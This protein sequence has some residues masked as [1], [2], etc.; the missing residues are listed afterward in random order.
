MDEMNQMWII[1]LIY[2]IWLTW[3]TCDRLIQVLWMELGHRLSSSRIWIG[4][5]TT[6]LVRHVKYVK[7]Q[8]STPTQPNVDI[9][10]VDIQTFSKSQISW[11]FPGSWYF[12]PRN[13]KI[14]QAAMRIS[15]P[16]TVTQCVLPQQSDPT[17][18]SHVFHH[19]WCR[20]SSR[21]S[22]HGH[23][24]AGWFPGKMMKKKPPERPRSFKCSIDDSQP[25]NMV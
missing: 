17:R 20:S 16:S 11:Y 2:L 10:Y 24:A 14:F 5:L 12:E 15:S 13:F 8:H 25:L 18:G 4:Y 1:Y 19:E 9:C 21:N 22:P 23:G 6:Q 3:K 7:F